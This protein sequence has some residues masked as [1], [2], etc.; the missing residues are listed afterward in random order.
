V[1]EVDQ[2][3]DPVDERVAEGH[4]RVDLAVRQA[5]DG[6]LREAFGLVDRVADEPPAEPA[7]EENA[8]DD[9]QPVRGRPL[10]TGGRPDGCAL[11]RRHGVWGRP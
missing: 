10:G 5:D 9:P 7:H 8:E 6:D 11:L 4:Q 3:D 2:L 1:G